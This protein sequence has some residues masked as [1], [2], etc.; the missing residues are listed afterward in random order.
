MGMYEVCAKCGHVGQN[1]YVD[2]I[3]AV[4]AADGKEA[5]AKVRQF[6]R[7]KHHHKD[8]I[9]YVE[10]ISRERFSEIICMNTVDPFLL[11]HNIQDQRRNCTLEAKREERTRYGRDEEEKRRQGRPRQLI[12]RISSANIIYGFFSEGGQVC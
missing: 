5:A 1:Y 2:K 11:C 4:I 7:V 3:F 9:R 12:K 8:A 10:K 6:P